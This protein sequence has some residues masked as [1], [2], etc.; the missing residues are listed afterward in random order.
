L[1]DLEIIASLAAALDIPLPSAPARE[2]FNEIGRHVEAFAGL[3][4]ESLGGGG[5][6]L[7]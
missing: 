1:P 7:K 3:A 2:I 4:Y 5:Q 6:L